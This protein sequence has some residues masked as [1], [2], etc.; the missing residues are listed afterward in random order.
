MRTWDAKVR[1]NRMQQLHAVMAVNRDADCSREVEGEQRG[2]KAE[3]RLPKQSPRQLP[4]CPYFRK[5]QAL[6]FAF[7]FEMQGRTIAP[8][9]PAL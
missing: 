3:N 2:G 5:R 1:C 7:H 4:P 9:L 8:A 6:Y